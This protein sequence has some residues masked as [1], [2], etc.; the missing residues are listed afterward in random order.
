MEPEKTLNS[1][2]NVEKENQTWGNHTSE[3]QAVLQIVII[4]MIQYWHKEQTNSTRIDQWNTIE[5]PEMEPQTYGQLIFHKAGRISTANSAN[6]LFSKWCW[7][8]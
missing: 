5:N 1:Q 2:S 8:S 6:G 7:D 4:K 3:L